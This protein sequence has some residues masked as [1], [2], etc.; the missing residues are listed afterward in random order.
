M[1]G[2]RLGGRGRPLRAAAVFFAVWAASRALLWESPFVPEVAALPLAQQAVVPF[3]EMPV[4]ALTAL[5]PRGGPVEGARRLVPGALREAGSSKGNVATVRLP[6]DAG[7]IQLAGDAGGD[8]PAAGLTPRL[9]AQPRRAAR[10]SGDAWLL[11]R[12]GLGPVRAQQGFIAPAYGARQIGAVIRF[13]LDPDSAAKPSLYL[14]GSKALER[15]RDEEVA[16]GLSLRPV[17]S[18]PLVVGAELRAGDVG[19]GTRLRPAIL[20]VTE[21]PI[22]RLPLRTEAE[23]YVQAGYVGGP[24]AT[25]FIDGQLRVTRRIA[26]LGRLELRAGGGA[27]GGAQRGA[28]RLDIGPTANVALPLGPVGTRLSADW[29]FRV[30]GDAIP[31]SGPALTLSAGF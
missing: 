14:R 30:S 1:N 21:L 26:E 3:S 20:A 16:L 5:P 25:P 27:W 15:S 22:M 10:W 2:V 24:Y 13:R 19:G 17:S 6:P 29:R 8:A 9:L 28:A 7:A 12:E 4:A 18:L 11:W 31:Q 23:A